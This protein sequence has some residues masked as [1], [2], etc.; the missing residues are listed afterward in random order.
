MRSGTSTGRRDAIAL[1]Q[2]RSPRANW[3]SSI[4]AP[5]LPDGAAVS[6]LPRS[7]TTL[8]PTPLARQIP[9][10]RAAQALEAADDGRLIR[11][12]PVRSRPGPVPRPCG[13]STRSSRGPREAIRRRLL[14][15][16]RSFRVRSSGSVTDVVH[17]SLPLR[18]DAPLPGAAS[19]TSA[20]TNI[21]PTMFEHRRAGLIPVVTEPLPPDRI[22]SA[23]SAHHPTI[24]RWR[25]PGPGG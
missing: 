10:C 24:R 19:T 25:Q 11:R 23:M 16:H 20:Q 3:S 7:D 5:S 18:K 8:T 21:S 9:T 4:F 17:G 2:G 22:P 13:R 1:R 12:G 6:R 14:A 15:H